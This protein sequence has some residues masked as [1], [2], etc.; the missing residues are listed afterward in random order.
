LEVGAT[1]VSDDE[2][3][4]D[5]V[6]ASIQQRISFRLSQREFLTRGLAGRNDAKRTGKYFGTAEVLAKLDAVLN[7]RRGKQD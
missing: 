4:S 3:L 7:A 5:F 1:R 2:S 6:E